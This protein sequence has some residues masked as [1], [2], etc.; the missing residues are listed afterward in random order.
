MIYYLYLMRAH[1]NC[2]CHVEWITKRQFF[3]ILCSFF[4]RCANILSLIRRILGSKLV[5]LGLNVTINSSKVHK[6]SILLLFLCTIYQMKAQLYIGPKVGLNYAGM[7]YGNENYL[8]DNAYEVKSILLYQGGLIFHYKVN[9]IWSLHTEL[10]YTKKG[11]KILKDEIKY[12]SDRLELTYLEV[13]ILFRVSFGNE[14]ARFYFNIGPHISYFLSGKGSFSSAVLRRGL[15]IEGDQDPSYVSNLNDD[16]LSY[17]LGPEESLTQGLE[18]NLS[19]SKFNSLQLG[20]DL[21]IGAS[22]PIINENQLLFIDLRYGYTQ[23]FLAQNIDEEVNVSNNLLR[24]LRQN[25][26]GA[27]RTFSLSLGFAFSLGDIYSAR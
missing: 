22:I 8:S 23:S 5:S 6:T 24:G 2:K 14:K 19:P 3:T 21:G 9:K 18:H 4:A 25:F 1:V 20:L 26:E 15:P 13:P 7:V 16:I 11:R 17:E 12:V 27:A 10:N